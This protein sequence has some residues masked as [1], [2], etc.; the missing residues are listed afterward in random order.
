MSQSFFGTLALAFSSL[1]MGSGLAMANG[2]PEVVVEIY[3]AED[4][5]ITSAAVDVETSTPV[6]AIREV[7]YIRACHSN[8]TPP[9]EIGMVEEGVHIQLT[10]VEDG[11]LNVDIRQ[12]ESLSME[13]FSANGQTIELPQRKVRTA[14]FLLDLTESGSQTRTLPGGGKVTITTQRR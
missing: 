13:K 10:R 12:A 9:C 14:T 3:S 8:R 1:C 2:N 5:L 4:N 6:R 11:K 7:P